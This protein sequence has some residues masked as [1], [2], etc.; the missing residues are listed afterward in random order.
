MGVTMKVCF[1]DYGS[2]LELKAFAILMLED[3]TLHTLFKEG[4]LSKFIHVSKVPKEDL[5]NYLSRMEKM[6]E[7]LI[8]K[9]RNEDPQALL[10][11]YDDPEAVIKVLE[12]YRPRLV[13]VEDGAA[14]FVEENV[15][16]ETVVKKLSE[17]L[18]EEE[19]SLDM[20]AL[21][22]HR[23]EIEAVFNMLS[24]YLQIVLRYAHRNHVSIEQALQGLAIYLKA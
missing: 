3:Q 6:F 18:S 1:L 2:F 23:D 17:A 24:T 9:L 4:F 7:P 14:S 20:G 10:Y 16:S 8:E 13:V 15:P 19:L 22:I 21:R 5:T 11:V 12:M